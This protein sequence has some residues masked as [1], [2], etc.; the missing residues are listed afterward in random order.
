MFHLQSVCPAISSLPEGLKF[1]N[2]DVCMEEQP[3]GVQDTPKPGPSTLGGGAQSKGDGKIYNIKSAPATNEPDAHGPNHSNNIEVNK[4][5]PGD[6][7][8]DNNNT[9]TTKRRSRFHTSKG[10]NRKNDAVK[11]PFSSSQGAHDGMGDERRHLASAHSDPEHISVVK[12]PA[13]ARTS[14]LTIVGPSIAIKADVADASKGNATHDLGPD[15]INQ[16]KAYRSREING[17]AVPS[18]FGNS[19]DISHSKTSNGTSLAVSNPGQEAAVP[20]QPITRQPPTTTVGFGLNS[21]PSPTAPLG[22]TPQALFSFAQQQ[23]YNFYHQLFMQQQLLLQQQ[24]QQQQQQF[25][26]LAHTAGDTPSV[27]PASPMF[28]G[29]L[30]QQV[31]QSLLQKH[32]QHQQPMP[33]PLISSNVLSMMQAYQQFP[34]HHTMVPF[35]YGPFT[36]F[37]LPGTQASALFNT[38]ATQALTSSAADVNSYVA[39]N[40]HH[41][42]LVSSTSTSLALSRSN[43]QQNQSLSNA[44]STPS[45]LAEQA[46]R[47]TGENAMLMNGALGNGPLSASQIF[48][49]LVTASVQAAPV[50]KPET[51]Q[52]QSLSLN[53]PT[54]VGQASFERKRSLGASEAEGPVLKAT[55]R[56]RERPADTSYESSAHVSERSISDSN[57]SGGG[58]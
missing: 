1:K 55:K 25:Q 45:S 26:L 41:T 7:D 16:P 50:P 48:P 51:D 6:D 29:M 36:P 17:T 4:D 23:Q 10:I 54:V 3:E 46:L 12:T 35:P 52:N 40:L 14:R 5:A 56:F 22:F 28:G 34:S 30:Q 42:P 9:T 39:S 8:D 58:P 27:L 20:T 33:A 44:S 43:L 32:A 37:I 38:A 57:N 47:A 21:F 13:T 53:S 15:L 2:S 49:H 11:F 18:G 24:Q 19:E 31:Q